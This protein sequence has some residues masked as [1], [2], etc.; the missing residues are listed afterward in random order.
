MFY[1]R[2]RAQEREANF[3]NPAGP[4]EGPSVIPDWKSRDVDRLVNG[5]I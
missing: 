3:T 4:W 2:H 5:L 1:A